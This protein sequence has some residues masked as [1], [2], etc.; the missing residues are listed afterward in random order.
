MLFSFFSYLY[1][2][3]H[4]E[5]SASHCVGALSWRDPKVVTAGV[6]HGQETE[7]VPPLLCQTQRHL[8]D[9]TRQEVMMMTGK[10]RC[11]HDMTKKQQQKT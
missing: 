1:S 4:H 10:S 6:P 9:T 11:R 8:Y 3:V 5:V 7:R 2:V